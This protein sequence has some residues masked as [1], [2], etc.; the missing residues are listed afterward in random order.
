MKVTKHELPIIY[1]ILS[2]CCNKCLY[3]KYSA[4]QN[5]VLNKCLYLFSSLVLLTSKRFRGYLDHF[6]SSLNF[7]HSTLITYHSS[8]I[9]LHSKYHT[10]LALS[11]NFHHSIFFTL[12][13][14]PI[15]VS[16]QLLFLFLFF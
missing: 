4:S 14:G 10:C 6:F 9:T 11:L 3:L 7:H 15:P 5:Y 8:L 12:F 16:V 13:M 1:F 2:K